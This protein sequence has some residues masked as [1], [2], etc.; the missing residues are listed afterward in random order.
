MSKLKEY[1]DSK[2]KKTPLQELMDKKL[3]KVQPELAQTKNTPNQ[4]STPKPAPVQNQAPIDPIQQLLAEIQAIKQE[5]Q[6]VQTNFVQLQ[7]AIQGQENQEEDQD[8]SGEE[9]ESQEEDENEDP[10]EINQKKRLIILVR[11]DQTN[12]RKKL[13]TRLQ[14]KVLSTIR[15]FCQRFLI[16]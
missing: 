3:K 13:K 6:L 8:R 7:E 5:L 9:D 14:L 11:P 4:V 1:L 2:R 12:L 10:E 15:R 16:N